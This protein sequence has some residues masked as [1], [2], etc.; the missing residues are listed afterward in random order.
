[1]IIDDAPVIAA[2]SRWINLG[3]LGHVFRSGTIQCC[4]IVERIG[5][6]PHWSTNRLDATTLVDLA[7]HTV[8]CC[9]AGGQAAL[10][11]YWASATSELRQLVEAHQL[12]E[13]FR[14]RPELIIEWRNI[15]SEK[16]HKSFGFS[17]VRNKLRK[18]AG[19]DPDWDL[20]VPFKAFSN[21]GSHPSA[22]SLASCTNEEGLG[23]NMGPHPHSDRFRIYTGELW[24]NMTR[25]TLAFVAALDTVLSD[26]PT[27]AERFPT[28]INSIL[29]YRRYFAAVTADQVIKYWMPRQE[30]FKE[31][32]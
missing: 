10:R 15:E 31:P 14:L 30:T 11:G 9:G 20:S 23:K 26:E 22:S 19:K 1:M 24:A 3:D 32:S 28:D 21:L 8:S 7:A 18:A 13:L 6:D 4:R 12:F 5:R 29:G 2:H 25:T 16:R 27:V 17:E